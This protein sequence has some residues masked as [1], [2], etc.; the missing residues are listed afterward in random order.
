MGLIKVI[1][2]C[3][4]STSTISQHL[5]SVLWAPTASF[6]FQNSYVGIDITSK[7]SDA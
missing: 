5:A 2:L 1:G 3:R 4:F 6:S 7:Y